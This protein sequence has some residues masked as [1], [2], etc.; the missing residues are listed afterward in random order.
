ML[1]N[2]KIHSTSFI[3]KLHKLKKNKVQIILKNKT[4][5]IE[6]EKH[7]KSVIILQYLH[8]FIK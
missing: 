2:L 6:I 5:E 7:L 1:Q 3:I 8:R 4:K